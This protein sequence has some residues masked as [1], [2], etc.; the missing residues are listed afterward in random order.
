MNRE[1]KDVHHPLSRQFFEVIVYNAVGRASEV[2]T[3]PAYALSHS[4]GNS[5][6][7]TGIVQWDF[8]QPGRGHKVAELLERYQA[9]GAEHP[10]FEAGQLASLQVRLQRRGQVGNA[11]ETWERSRLNAYLRSEDG[12]SFVETLNQEQVDYKWQRV[13][14]PLAS[15]PWLVELGARD[16]AA[17]VEITT[18]AAKLFNQNEVR[19]KRL[20]AHLEQNELSPEGTA[21]WIGTT[22]VAGLTANARSAILSGRDQARAGAALLAGLQYGESQVSERWREVVARGDTGLSKG[23]DF[24]PDLQLF[25]ALLRHPHHGLRVLGAIEGAPLQST[26][27][28]RGINAL[29]REEMAEIQAGPDEGIL[30]TTTR[31]TAYVLQGGQWSLA[32]PMHPRRAADV[33]DHTEGMRQL[34]TAVA[35][36]APCSTRTARL[37]C[38]L[39]ERHGIPVSAAELDQLARSLDVQAA[40]PARGDVTHVAFLETDVPAG[41]PGARVAA[42]QGDPAD[43]ASRWFTTSLEESLAQRAPG[44]SRQVDDNP[45]H[46]PH[47][48][49]QA[50]SHPGTMQPRA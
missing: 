18:M 45:Q 17:A 48:M 28:I 10:R 24:N 20:L 43:P 21:E 26:V 15:I 6:W 13:G 31:G 44:L 30:L 41:L 11:L 22:G 37:L 39:Y 16:P 9:W 46:G 36:S 14:Q 47:S 29:A 7:S 34:P 3:Y 23:F 38:E 5:G 12:R 32:R 27:R 2:N 1:D 42:W 4:T 8:G 19:G 50:Q 33:P 35:E 49:A 40:S 25:D